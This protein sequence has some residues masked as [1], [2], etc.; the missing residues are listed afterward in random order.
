MSKI[1]G[2]DYT[3]IRSYAGNQ[4]T[5]PTRK[6][7]E[8]ICKAFNVTVED[9]LRFAELNIDQESFFEILASGFRIRD[10]D[11]RNKV[12]GEYLA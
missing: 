7:F 5:L 3:T 10:R 2:I 8:T 9:F 6:N 12:K 11:L 1:T 4:S